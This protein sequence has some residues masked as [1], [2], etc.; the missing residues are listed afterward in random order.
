[1]KLVFPFLLILSL[2]HVA[3]AQK[4]PLGAAEKGDPSAPTQLSDPFPPQVS[5]LGQVVVNVTSGSATKI[6]AED[7]IFS[8][9]DNATPVQNLLLGIR[10]AGSGT[11]FPVD[12]SG[13][14]VTLPC[15]T[16]ATLAA[17]ST[18]RFGSWTLPGI[19][20]CAPAL[21]TFLTTLGRALVPLS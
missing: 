15:L 4:T 2:A 16:A 14:P 18:S 6:W 17:A 7:L 1:M 11:G 12:S 21:W 20:R 19:R 8:Y 10:R 9:S 13:N 5:C 3:V